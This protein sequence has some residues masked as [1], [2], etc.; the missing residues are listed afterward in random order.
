M[1]TRVLLGCL[2]LATAGCGADR[3][4][5]ADPAQLHRGTATVL[6]SPAH[7]PEL[8]LGGQQDSYPPQCGGVPITNWDWDAVDGQESANGTTWGAYTVVGTF[9]GT[10][11]TLTEPPGAPDRADGRGRTPITSPCAEAEPATGSGPVGPDGTGPAAERA[12]TLPD[13]AGLWITGDVLNVATAGDPAAVRAPLREVWGG[14]L[15]LVRHERTLAALR[16]VQEDLGAGGA[17]ELGLTLLWSATDEVGNVVELGVVAIDDAQRAAL[18]E[19]YGAG[20]VVATPGLVPE[21]R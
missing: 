18:D 2:V 4:Q 1:R 14:P 13:H 16:A 8:C 15:C 21:P 19:R 11:L 9:D 5:T 10:S 12:R 3:L 7:G 17:E 6:E 20:A